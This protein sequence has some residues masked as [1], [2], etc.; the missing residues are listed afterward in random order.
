MSY[1]LE[2]YLQQALRLNRAVERVGRE[3]VSSTPTWSDSEGSGLSL[4][5][6]TK[7]ME[8]HLCTAD[9]PLIID[10]D[11]D[12]VPE[13]VRAALLRVGWTV[14]IS[15]PFDLTRTDTS[16]V[17]RFARAVAD[18]GDG[19]VYDPQLDEIVW[20]RSVKKLRDVPPRS[21]P[22]RDQHLALEWLFARHLTSADADTLLAVAEPRMPEA[23]P[24]RFG[25]FEPMQ[26]RLE[27]D[28]KAAFSALF[29]EDHFLF[30]KGKRPF[31]WGFVHLE[32]GWGSALPQAERDAR[33]PT[34]GGRKGVSPDSIRLEFEPGL[35]TDERWLQALANLFRAVARELEPFFA[36]AY[37]HSGSFGLTGR[38]WLGIPPEP[39]WLTWVGKP[40]LR[41]SPAK[42]PAGVERT[43]EYLF[44]S[45][46][47]SPTDWETLRVRELPWDARL[48]RK[49]TQLEEEL[50]A[51]VIPE[52]H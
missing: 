13:V 46:S 21:K 20:P 48:C 32:R 47:D 43:D 11:D 6:R 28:G 44:V 49:G 42:T 19:V 31:Q 15:R 35:A 22:D 18:K 23:M 50:A 16:V 34:L 2:V 52:L 27:R 29:D 39:L 7:R 30:W 25:T 12:H 36:G 10:E 40:Y 1:D 5:R 45:A 9:G 24:H 26:G 3:D 17:E 37:F 14:Q 4:V 41:E 8:R 33:T 38:Y 51:E